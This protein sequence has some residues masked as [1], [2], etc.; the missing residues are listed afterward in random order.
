MFA[1]RLLR[2]VGLWSRNTPPIPHIPELGFQAASAWQVI[3]CS[4]HE[5]REVLVWWARSVEKEHGI[6]PSSWASCHSM[7]SLI[8]LRII[9]GPV[10]T[11]Q[12]KY[13]LF[14][15][16]HKFQKIEGHRRTKIFAGGSDIN[17]F[18]S[19]NRAT[20]EGTKA[21]GIES[22]GASSQTPKAK[23]QVTR[24]CSVSSFLRNVC[25]GRQSLPVSPG[26]RSPG[27]RCLPPS[28]ESP[29]A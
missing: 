17:L 25:S 20:I 3:P 21:E 9:S 15:V 16:L 24:T 2:A 22:I 7:A 12:S 18:V 29:S 1:E 8:A 6:P 13:N 23:G 28:R 10:K 26:L 27:W 19:E 4:E 5:D 14:I 11:W